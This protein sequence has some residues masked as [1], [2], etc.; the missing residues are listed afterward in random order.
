VSRKDSGVVWLGEI[1]GHWTVNYLGN[2]VHVAGGATPSKENLDFWNGSIP[3]VSPKDMKREVLSDSADHVTEL[4]LRKSSL[5]LIPVPAVL[6]VIRGMILDHTVPIAR[7]SCTVTVNQ[8]MKALRPRAGLSAEYL[9]HF[10]RA[11]N[12]ALLARVEEAGHGTKALR[13]DLWRKL[14]V[15]VPSEAEQH[16]IVSF[17][18]RKTAAIDALIAKKERL[19]E[20][21]Q[22]KRQALI[23]QA[24]TKGLDPNVAMKD[25]EIEWLGVVPHHWR[26]ARLKHVV[27][28]IIDCPHT[29]PQCIDAGDFYVIRTADI[30]WGRL[31]LDKARR[32]S[33]ETYTERTA[34]LVPREGDVMYSREGERFGM[35]ALVPRAVRLCLGQRMMMFRPAT[36]W[37]RGEH[38][39]WFLN[40]RAAYNQVVQDTTGATAPRVNIPTVANLWVPVPPLEEQ[41]RLADALGRHTTRIDQTADAVARHIDK[42]RE[43]RQALITAAVKGKID[44]S[45]EAA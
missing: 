9:S 30:D 22:E 19:I 8:D 14:P 13:T 36:D 4:A 39:N 3:W 38:L 7:T 45:T 21:L 34:R 35:A 23:T 11:M 29:T 28:R 12:E 42:L 43:Y 6:M 24:V 37:V 44:V 15:L 1:P 31:Y 16:A 20:L 41:E 40:S 27:A 26:I 25:S 32:V 5:R 17:L 10:L 18:D 2:L 33:E